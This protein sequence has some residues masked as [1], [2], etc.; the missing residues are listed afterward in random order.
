MAWDGELMRVPILGLTQA[1][2]SHSLLLDDGDLLREPLMSL[3][4][5][6]QTKNLSVAT[7]RGTSFKEFGLRHRTVVADVQSLH[8]T[9]D[10]IYA[11]GPLSD[12]R[13]NVCS[14]WPC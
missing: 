2:D 1:M 4:T 12:N 7:A 3:S 8:D 6:Q 5:K 11:C 9:W 14:F 10:S 13:R